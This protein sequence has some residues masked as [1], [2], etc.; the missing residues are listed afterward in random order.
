MVVT[1]S[2]AR[3]AIYQ[4]EVSLRTLSTALP[5][6]PGHFPPKTQKL[7]QPSL[8]LDQHREP[9]LCCR[10]KSPTLPQG[11]AGPAM[12]ERSSG[13]FNLFP[14]QD[15]AGSRKATHKVLSSSSLQGAGLELQV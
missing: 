8:S 11:L 3:R 1:L 2:P 15:A 6:Q 9:C 12:K 7:P 5:T 10:Q 13:P 14:G 4:A